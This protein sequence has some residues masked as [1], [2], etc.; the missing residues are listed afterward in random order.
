V[1]IYENKKMKLVEIVLKGRERRK[2]ME[3]VYLRYI[4]VSPVQLLYANNIFNG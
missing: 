2:K 1:F 4:V 3:G